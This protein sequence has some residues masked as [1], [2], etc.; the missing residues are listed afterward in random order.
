MYKQIFNKSDGAPK[1]IETG[2]F[3]TEQYTEVQPPNGLYQP[4]HFDGKEWIGTPYEEWIANHP[5]PDE[6]EEIPDEKDEIIADLSIQLLEAQNAIS[7]VRN[8]VANLTIQLL[9]RE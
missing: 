2:I 6:V 3:D 1:L 4:I 5:K 8:D 9:E 7:T